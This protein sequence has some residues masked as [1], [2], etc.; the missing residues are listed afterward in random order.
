MT[1]S[2]HSAPLVPA[3]ATIRPLKIIADVCA[4]RFL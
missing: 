2:G 4:M 3:P 1:E